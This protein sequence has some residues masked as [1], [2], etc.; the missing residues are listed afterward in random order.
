MNVR[1]IDGHRH[2]MCLEAHNLANSLNP[3]KATSM[4]GINEAS[5][6]VNLG[7]APDWI[8]K[9]TD[10]EEH[11]SDMTNAGIDVG[12]V[13]PPPPGFYYWAE[14]SA[15]SEMARMVNENTSRIV[16]LHGSRLVGLASLPMQD[17]E[18][19][20]SELKHAV[21]NLGLSGVAIASNINGTG[22]DQDR[23]LP[24][25]EEIQSLDVPI[26]I[27]PDIPFET[28][29]MRD[30]YLVNLLGYPMDST[31]AACQLVFGGILDQYPHL[32]VCLVHA[33]G[34]LPFLLGRIEHGQSVRP[35]TREKCRKTFS[36]YLRNFYVD[37]V[38][39]RSET[40]RFVIAVM[41]EGHVFMGT[42]YPF[43]MAEQHPVS[44]IRKAIPDNEELVG[45]I[46]GKNLA[47]LLR[48]GQEC[49]S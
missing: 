32:K 43:D 24:L 8:R 16:R 46:L 5:V 41:P 37:S 9:M 36:S 21:R 39:F 49:D 3:A 7:K 34:V 40:L 1:V 2:L 13:W 18:R 35:E 47:R 44:F 15:G 28:D 20:I 31:L 42:D 6:M 48:I 22:L 38:T 4:A 14:P 30:Y 27:H 11:I 19:S 26:F 29:R 23:F 33:G 17:I 25:F 10:F 12:V 45:Q